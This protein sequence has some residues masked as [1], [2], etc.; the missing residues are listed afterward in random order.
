[1][2]DSPAILQSLARLEK[3]NDALK[4]LETAKSLK[5]GE[6]AWSD[7]LLAGNA[8]Y[9]KLEQG[10]KV[11]GGKAAGWFGR[12]K[13]ER[14]DDPLL[15]Y[16]HHARNSDEHGIEDITIRMGP[17]QATITIR[18]PFDP[19]KLEGVQLTMGPHRP[20][21]VQV[22]SSNEDVVSTKIYDKPSL[23][24]VR[25]KDSRFGDHYD[26]PYEH[27]GAKLAD[28]SPHSVGALFVAYLGRLIDDARSF[29]I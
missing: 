7:L 3:A 23:V 29:G 19:A 12:A 2:T 26:P 13:K 24:L 27:L 18:E 28:Q 6:S 20:G 8:V 21:H 10:S 14:K 5:E 16:M 4:R 22:S 25:V 11:S 15:S 9:S 17:G 1:M